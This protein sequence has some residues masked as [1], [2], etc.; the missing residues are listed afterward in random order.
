MIRD[1]EKML[2]ALSIDLLRF[3]EIYTDAYGREQRCINLPKRECLIL[4]GGYD[5][6]LRAS[7]IDRWAELE[8]KEQQ[9]ATPM[10]EEHAALGA[11]QEGRHGPAVT[12]ERY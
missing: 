2:V 9:N 10:N 4:A 1:I 12:L 3:E 8:Y 6:V 11:P 7:I 5:V